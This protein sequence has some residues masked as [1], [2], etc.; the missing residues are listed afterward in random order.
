MTYENLPPL[1]RVEIEKGKIKNPESGYPPIG[2]R[3]EIPRIALASM[4]RE[5]LI[6]IPDYGPWH[7]INHP[8]RADGVKK[9]RNVERLI[10]NDNPASNEEGQRWRDMGLWTDTANR[11]LHPRFWQLLTTPDVGMYTGPG[12]H[13]GNG[14]QRMANLGTRRVRNGKVEYATIRKRA[15]LSWGLPGGYAEAHHETLEDA[16]FD[17][18][19]QEAGIARAKLGNYVARHVFS[20]PKGFR[21]DTLHSWGEEYF[22]FVASLDNPELEGVE[23]EIHD[24]DEIIDAAWVDLETIAAHPDFMGTHRDRTLEAEGIFIK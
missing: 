16:A 4:M 10:T 12:F 18:G 14:P 19:W 13:Y 21:R 22:I 2:D 7:I 5:G 1:T 8:N 17:E 6:H 20:P 23:L 24:T 15:N 9:G 3:L 11:A